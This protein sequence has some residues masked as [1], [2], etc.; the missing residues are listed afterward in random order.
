M[1]GDRHV[2][3]KPVGDLKPITFDQMELPKIHTGRYVVCR[4]L[5]EA[6]TFVGTSTLVED[7]NGNVEQVS[8]YNFRPYID[9]GWLPVGTILVIKEPFVKYG[10]FGEDVIIRVDSP[11][12]VI[13]VDETDRPTLESFGARAWYVAPALTIEC[14]LHLGKE[15][16]STGRYEAALKCFDRAALLTPDSGAVQLNRADVLTRMERF[17][18]AYQA[19]ETA[20]A[21]GA[22]REKALYILGKASYGKRFWHD[23]EKHF[24]QLAVEFPDK[25]CV[26][27]YLEQT[28]ERILESECGQYDFRRMLMQT[29]HGGQKRLDVADFLGPVEISDVHGKGKGLVASRT[30]KKGTLLIVSK[31]FS[32]ACENEWE[33]GRTFAQ[34]TV[35]KANDVSKIHLINSIGVI[36]GLQRNPHRAAELYALYAGD[37]PRGTNIPEGIIDAGR[38][39]RICCYNSFTPVGPRAGSVAEP[40]SAAG[41]W[42]IPS[43]VNHACI[44]NAERVFFGDV[45]VV[46]AIQDLKKGEEIVWSYTD[47]LDSFSL[48]TKH[49]YP[50]GF[51]CDCRLCELDRADGDDVCN[52]R[53]KL[54]KQAASPDWNPNHYELSKLLEKLN[55]SYKNHPGPHVHLFPA[56]SSMAYLYRKE[57]NHEAALSCHEAAL[58]ALGDH[59]KYLY[60]TNLLLHMVE[61]CVCLR[62]K[63]LARRYALEALEMEK[64]RIGADK[65]LFELIYPEF[66]CAL[67]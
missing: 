26:S 28:R 4:T 47:A 30:I 34:V 5:T 66:S 64:V 61:E 15:H 10:S 44:E 24:V 37:L 43:F 53:A 54:A 45:M 49:L 35:G 40:S 27:D 62:R 55:R 8:L 17:Y 60:G 38:I 12:D 52:E 1:T 20:L 6:Y 19:A 65:Q 11:S 63:D 32:L 56:L 14:L 46:H 33:D 36:Q 57:G 3:L 50:Y 2:C 29:R 9:D 16:A 58:R 31:A 39:E 18:D 48:R 22:G 51:S 67:D 25:L 7:L 42:T 21:N 59:L 41:L 13:F 23:A